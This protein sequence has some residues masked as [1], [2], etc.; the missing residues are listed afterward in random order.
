[1]DCI[2]F[3]FDG[4]LTDLSSQAQPFHSLVREDL[5]RQLGQSA[6]V[7]SHAW[8]EVADALRAAPP[9]EG[10]TYQGRLVAPAKADPYLFAGYITARLLDRFGAAP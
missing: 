7:I 10:W 1:M 5:C 3:D 8:D 4:T 9:Y 6:D 2:I